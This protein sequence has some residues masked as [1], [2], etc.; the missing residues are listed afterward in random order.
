M[1]RQDNEKAIYDAIS[2]YYSIVTFFFM[3]NV[4]GS[5]LLISF[6]AFCLV[7]CGVPVEEK[8]QNTINS[9]LSSSSQTSESSVPDSTIVLDEVPNGTT[10]VSINIAPLGLSMKFW[11]DASYWK[12][13]SLQGGY[14]NDGSLDPTK[15]GEYYDRMDPKADSEGFVHAINYDRKVSVNVDDWSVPRSTHDTLKQAITD[16]SCDVLKNPV[17]F[18][19]VDMQ[20]PHLCK[21]I[22]PASDSTLPVVVLMGFKNPTAYTDYPEST[23]LIL[24]EKQAI[25][26]TGFEPFTNEM[27]E[28]QKLFS[29]LSR[30]PESEVADD[31][32]IEKYLEATFSHPLQDLQTRF[33]QLVTIARSLNLQ[34]PE[35]KNN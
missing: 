20:K 14:V 16:A 35:A 12:T 19:P 22:A 28:Y 5:K 26:M 25:I 23:I 4:H 27:K 32:S 3:P 8:T 13:K 29:K 18:L 15:K 6:V 1:T 2:C 34:V 21:V 30:P 7:S 10:Q 9:S 31:G 17:V 33:D 24:S 11:G